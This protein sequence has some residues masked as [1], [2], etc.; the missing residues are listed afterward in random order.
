MAYEHEFVTAF[1]R[2]DAS[3]STTTETVTSSGEANISESIGINA[4]DVQVNLAIDVSALKSIFMLASTNM[5]IS[6]N[7]D[8]DGAFDDQI[9]LIAGR[10]LIW[11]NTSY[12]DSPFASTVDVAFIR[13]VNG[14]VAGTLQI[15]ALQDAT[16]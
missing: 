12:F 4:D 6:T 13:V 1:A 2:D 11:T 15:C 9:F 16:P 7:N 5:T 10:P 8:H 14:G 3:V